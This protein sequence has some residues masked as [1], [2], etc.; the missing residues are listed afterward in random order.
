MKC[1]SSSL[2]PFHA[3]AG[4]LDHRLA[5]GVADAG[6]QGVQVAELGQGL[7]RDAV[8]VS[9]QGSVAG[10]GQGRAAQG[11]HLL[12]NR[13]YAGFGKAGNG[14]VGAGLGKGQGNTLADTPA[15][16]GNQYFLSGNFK[17]GKTHAAPSARLMWSWGSVKAG[18][19][20]V[21][22]RQTRNGHK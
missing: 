10:Q 1:H 15:R 8:H 17:L 12:G 9:G 11:A 18:E 22:G 19:M 21:N 6:D 3:D 4:E 14:N 20:S 16:A 7:L 13:I 2:I 5:D